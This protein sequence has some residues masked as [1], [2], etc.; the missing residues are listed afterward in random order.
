MAAIL[1]NFEQGDDSS[2]LVQLHE[3]H[4][5]GFGK[6]TVAAKKAKKPRAPKPPLTPEEAMQQAHAGLSYL[7][8][9]RELVENQLIGNAYRVVVG[10]AGQ[11]VVELARPIVLKEDHLAPWN[12]PPPSQYGSSKTSLLGWTS[13]M[14][15]PSFSLPAGAPEMGGACP[16]AVAGQSVVPE[17][18]LN[19]ARRRLAVVGQPIKSWEAICQYCYAT[20]GQYPTVAV[21]IAQVVRY[22]WAREAVRQGRFAYVM[23]YAVKNANY[24]LSEEVTGRKFFRIH[25][26]GDFFSQEYLE[27]WATVATMNPDVTFW[28]PSRIWATTWGNAAVNGMSRPDNFIIRP[29]VYHVGDVPTPSSRELGMGWDAGTSVLPA[30][31]VHDDPS[32][33]A[34]SEAKEFYD[35]SCQV[36]AKDEKLE[37]KNC[38]AAKSPEGSRGC[39]A[40]WI[41]PAMRINYTLH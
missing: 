27:Q 36:Y 25:D 37:A 30:A 4:F 33:P 10:D 32:P 6:T 16:G 13:K 19:A 26:S 24:D 2:P 18:A 14:S 1:P 11:V 22:V 9:L 15:A 40:C 17:A 28:A 39:R 31:R 38:R 7:A 3:G 41:H 34:G 35:W 20:G 29:S 5:D 21:Q 8:W 23:D 12:P